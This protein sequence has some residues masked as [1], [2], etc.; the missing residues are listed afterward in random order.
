MISGNKTENGEKKINRFKTGTFA[1]ILFAALFTTCLAGCGG[2]TEDNTD[3]SVTDKAYDISD[4]YTLSKADTDTYHDAVQDIDM[5]DGDI[6]TITEAGAYCI[7]GNVGGQIC[8]DV[9]DEIVYLILE[10]A[11]LHA[12]NGPAIDV[13]SAAKVVI[14][15]P[16]DTESTVSDTAYYEGFSDSKACIYSNCDLTI[17]GG[18]SL[19]VSGYYKDAIRT[20]DV[21]K[22]L[23]V[24]LTVQSKKNGLRGNDGVILEDS[25][26]DIQCEGTG[27]YTKTD[28][29]KNRG[30]VS[31]NGGEVNI[32]AGEYG[33]FVAENVYIQDCIASVTGVEQDIVCDREEYIQE[34]CL[35]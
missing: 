19:K 27:I 14:S 15:V 29:K 33:M 13:V 5:N 2:M 7:T 1:A 4:V 28:S 35:Q 3:I 17:N 11:Y 22:V 24:S 30:F 18:G 16:E 32:I 12:Y 9:Q 10:N 20:K 6:Y 21:L 34:G 31:I 23:N 26:A 25:E 8:I